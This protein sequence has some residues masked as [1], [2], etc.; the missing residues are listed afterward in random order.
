MTNK[1]DS[2]LH[3]YKMKNINITMK[4]DEMKLGSLMSSTLSV[5]P[6]LLL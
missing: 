2:L 3:L 4:F 1:I 6:N 5:T